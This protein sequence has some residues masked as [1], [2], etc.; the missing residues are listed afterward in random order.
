MLY[1]ILSDI[2]G[3]PAAFEV[4]L[5]DARAQGAEKIIC[6]GD[7]VGYGPDAVKSVELAQS[8]CDEVLMGN[9]DAATT[10]VI[11]AANFRPEARIG[12]ER[13]A[14]ELSP[15]AREWLKTRPYTCRGRTF[16]CAHGTLHYPEEFRYMFDVPDAEASFNLMQDLRLL[17]VGHTHASMW[18]VRNPQGFISGGRSERM[19]LLP[20]YQYIVNVGSVGYPRCERESVYVLYETRTRVVTWRRLPFDFDSYFA[21]MDAKGIFIAPWLKDRAKEAQEAKGKDK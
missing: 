12:A 3:N 15:E 13:H 7:V 1:A 20:G 2:H 6:L 10:G 16:W 9:H 17:F 19:R 21:Q 14:R 11:S 5:A 8:S 4:A 18:I